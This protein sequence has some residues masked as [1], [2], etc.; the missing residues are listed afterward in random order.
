M[1]GRA[2]VR[3]L[4]VALIVVSALFVPMSSVLGEGICV[5]GQFMGMDVDHLEAGYGATCTADDTSSAQAINYSTNPN[6]DANAGTC[7]G[8]GIGP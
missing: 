1:V 6:S 8:H 5:D 3:L 4:A 7:V 2:P